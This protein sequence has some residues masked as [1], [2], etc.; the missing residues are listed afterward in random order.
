MA[1]LEM[2]DGPKRLV[3]LVL[4]AVVVGS[5]VF[6]IVSIES[7][8]VQAANSSTIEGTPHLNSSAPN[9]RLNPGQSGSVSVSIT[10]DATYDYNNGTHPQGAIDR[11]GEARSVRVNISDTR[12][13]PITVETGEQAVGTIQDG[14]T[15]GPHTF[16]VV[17]DEDAEA[18]TYEV[19]VTER[20]RHAKRVQYQEVADGEYAYNETIVNR[21]ETSTISVVIEPEARFEVTGIKHDVPLG[22]EGTVA[23]AVKNTGDLD[24]TESSVSLSSSDSDFYFGSGTATSDASVG[25]WN[26]SETKFLTYRAGTVDSAVKREYPFDMSVS[27]LDDDEVQQSDSEQIGIT[28][29]NRTEFE[30]VAVS[31][32]I[33]RNGEGTIT[34]T[35]EHTAGKTVSDVRVTATSS[36]SEVYL[37]A[38]SSRSANTYVGEWDD[39]DRKNLTFRVGTSEDAV[40]RSY[41][42]EL[43]FDYTD[44]DDNDNSQNEF[45]EFVPQDEDWFTVNHTSHDIPQNG[46]GLFEVNVTQIADKPISDVTVTA[47]TTSSEVYFGSEGSRSSTIPLNAWNASDQRRLTFRAGTTASTVNRTYPIDLQF[48]FT[49][50]D[51]NDNSRSKQVEFR[52][53]P[54]EQ[55]ELGSIDH[56]IPQNGEGLF[57]V[58]VTQIADKPISDV[59]VTASTTSSEVYFGSEGSRSSTIPL[60]AWNASDQQELTFRVGTTDSAVNRTYPIDLQFDYS[61]DKD[62]DNSRSKQVEF[63]PGPREQFEVGRLEHTIPQDGEG[64]L[65]ITVTQVA[66]KPISDVRV[67]ASTTSPSVYLGTESSRSSTTA[68]RRWNA[69]DQ[70]Q[71]VFRAG[72]TDSVVN[73][74]YP[75]DLQFE[76]TDDNDNDNARTKQIEFRPGPRD[77][78]TVANVTH[79]VPQN[80]VGTVT[81]E[82]ENTAEKPLLDLAGTL[83]TTDTEVYI[84]R[85]SSRSGTATVT[86][87]EPGATRN[88]TF[89]VG[90]SENAVNRSYPLDLSLEYTDAEDNNNQQTEQISFRPEPEPQFRVVSVE[91]NAP[92][93]GV[94]QVALT[95]QNAGPVDAKAASLSINSQ[96]DAL[97][98][99]SGGSSEPIEGPGGISFEPPQAGTP[100]SV[101]YIGEWAAGTNRTVYFRVGFDE[102]A[103]QHP[104]TSDLTVAYEND[105]GDSMPSQ[106][107]SIGLEPLP[108][109]VFSV[110]GVESDLH[111]GEDGDIIGTVTNDGNRTAEG[112]V[113]TIENQFQNI[114]FYNPRYAVGDLEPGESANVRFRVG[115]TEEAEHGPRLFEISSRYRDPDSGKRTT[116]SRDM[117][118]RI[119]ADRD[120]FAVENTKSTLSPGESDRLVVTVTNNRDETLSNIQAK[121]FTD[122]PLDSEDDEAFIQELNP[123]ESR[124][125]KMDISAGG[126]AM[127]K[128]YSVS[129]DFRFDN[130][131]GEST[132]SDTYRVA[133]TVDEDESGFGT[134]L[135]LGG[136]L[137]ILAAGVLGWRVGSHHRLQ[138]MLGDETLLERFRS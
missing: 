47:S 78:F 31:H 59:T 132:L 55:F 108:E 71:L 2:G 76:Y 20:Y 51:D 5:A 102:N 131:R 33:P 41:S 87:I 75:I 109:P 36:E 9:A 56:D 23:V 97:Y 22:G 67:T 70:R 10:N 128:N 45:V 57:E 127:P 119:D 66:D 137:V 85:E 90:A 15:S 138:E 117:M 91:H 134:T 104:Y 113:L 111:V 89:H 98:F 112:I 114:N 118:V 52:P 17:V 99:G 4:V 116:D 107:M 40:N 58:N 6:G 60:N 49:D 110:E 25:Q 88:L 43:Q 30:A 122:D 115:V 124:K 81:I 123:G 39:S 79:H 53:N 86:E 82:I 72:T 84:G 12:T 35:V 69:S 129:M 63:R 121:L 54:R 7:L 48:D 96:V 83:S 126:S 34:V 26:A 38:Q 44:A 28:P 14:E 32:D 29:T 3:A 24:V 125:L 19:E 50:S 135:L 80:G 65:R 1:D 37:G 95:I 101:A 92:V 16:N 11:A 93:G 77:H 94:G 42:L 21:T 74:T 73:Q 8:P 62:N 103:I 64:T 133:V 130:A 106:S 120:S 68:L 105:A 61:D 46:E 100:T 136:L 13:A 18:G 27:Y